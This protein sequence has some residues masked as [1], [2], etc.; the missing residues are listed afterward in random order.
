MDLDLFGIMRTEGHEALHVFSDP[1]SGLCAIIAIHSTRL[2]PALGGCRMWPYRAT[3]E[4][5]QDAFIFPR[6]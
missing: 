4:A 1:G 5:V 3:E 2:G 6:Q